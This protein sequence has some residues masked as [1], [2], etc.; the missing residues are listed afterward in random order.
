[1]IHIAAQVIAPINPEVSNDEFAYQR[2]LDESL[3]FDVVDGVCL[4]VTFKHQ[5]ITL[6][7]R[8]P[9]LKPDMAVAYQGLEDVIELVWDSERFNARDT[10]S[11]VV[12]RKGVNDL[13]S[14]LFIVGFEGDNIFL[15]TRKT[16]VQAPS[17]VTHTDINHESLE[18]L[19]PRQWVASMSEE[20]LAL[21]VKNKAKR[22][23]LAQVK[24]EESIAALEK[25]VDL[26][27]EL[28]LNIANL[29]PEEERPEW[30]SDFATQFELT[31]STKFKG[32]NAAVTDVF[33]H[34]SQVRN[35]QATYFDQRSEIV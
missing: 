33:S 16:I 4:K 1:M 30:L 35:I 7:P 13:T 5:S 31:R 10:S 17:E 28:V 12:E 21:V 29:I 25:Q 8:R 2:R 20:L 6:D 32:S 18:F 3:A 22:R 27:S 9:Y 15:V 19:R 11:S 24:P 34:K 26:L 23:L 14:H